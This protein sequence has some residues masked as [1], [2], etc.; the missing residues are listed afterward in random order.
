M[1]NVGTRASVWGHK[2]IDESQVRVDSTA[3][4]VTSLRCHWSTDAACSDTQPERRPRRYKRADHDHHE[5]KCSGRLAE[6]EGPVP[7]SEKGS[8]VERYAYAPHQN[9]ASGSE[10]KATAS[11]PTGLKSTSRSPT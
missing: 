9:R 11:Q 2:E 8:G 4:F 5:R 3:T 7:A 1:Q 10:S 6:I